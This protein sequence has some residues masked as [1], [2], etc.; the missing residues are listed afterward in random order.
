MSKDKQTFTDPKTGEKMESTWLARGVAGLL[1][2]SLFGLVGELLMTGFSEW[3]GFEG[4]Q[5][6]GLRGM[7]ELG[8]SYGLIFGLVTGLVAAFNGDFIRVLLAHKGKGRNSGFWPIHDA[9]ARRQHRRRILRSKEHQDVPDTALSRAQPPGAPVP[10]DAA[11]SLADTTDEKE[12]L[13]SD[14][15][16]EDKRAVVETEHTE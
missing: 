16:T 13:T 12:H 3:A 4:R 5:V 9:I 14:V 8:V 10:T 1:F 7:L 15:E 6:A 2:G 11:L